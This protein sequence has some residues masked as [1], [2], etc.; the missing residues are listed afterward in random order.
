MNEQG[1]LAKAV[2]DSTELL[3]G[4][5]L[6]DV[7]RL[8]DALAKSRMIPKDLWGKR[9]DVVAV[10]L[11]GRE[12]GLPPMAALNSLFV[13]NGKTGMASETMLALVRKSPQCV[14]IEW[15]ETN[16]RI[17][18]L[19]Y[20]RKG[21]TKPRKFSFTLQQA[22]AAGVGNLAKWPDAMLRARCASALVRAEFSD[23]MVGGIY[24][25]TS[26]ELPGMEEPK[27]INEP[28][29]WAKGDLPPVPTKQELKVALEQAH[30]EHMNPPPEEPE[31]MN[32][33]LIPADGEISDVIRGTPEEQMKAKAVAY[34]D[35]IRTLQLEEKLKTP[36][37]VMKWITDNVDKPL[38][39]EVA[40]LVR[41]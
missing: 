11:R 3:G 34:V 26:G 30:V 12:L 37:S 13:I 28:P 19:E 32:D 17:A 31:E 21:M 15:A 22:Q 10:I 35:T 23:V 4:L 25:T 18:T 41:Q 29:V 24:D 33:S 40:R 38:R 39:Y 8:A 36:A 6:N 14:S 7:F 16:G 2:A 1:T 20:M 9:D 5:A 27:E